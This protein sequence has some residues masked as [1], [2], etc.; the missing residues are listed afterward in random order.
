MRICG[1]SCPESVRQG[2]RV[3]GLLFHF[4][5]FLRSLAV[6]IVW[7]WFAQVRGE[8]ASNKKKK[9]C[10][11]RRSLGRWDVSSGAPS[12]NSGRCLV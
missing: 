9:I 2:S 10:F 8:D 4:E 11:E 1:E 6:Q 7:A 5:L 3:L 12:W